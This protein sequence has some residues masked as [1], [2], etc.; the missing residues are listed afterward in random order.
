MRPQKPNFV[1]SEL[2]H[3]V[4]R[5][6]APIPFDLLIQ[7]LGCYAVYGCQVP[8]QH[9]VVPPNAENGL[10]DFMDRDQC[11][12]RPLHGQPFQMVRICRFV[13]RVF[14][15]HGPS[16]VYN[17]LTMLAKQ[18]APKPLSMLTTATFEAQLLSI[19]SSAAMPPKLAP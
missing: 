13:S 10:L 12:S 5:E 8:I 11:R 4:L 7:A 3:E 2:K 16:L 17:R 19:P 9:D 18:A 6:S 14:G 1:G 15:K